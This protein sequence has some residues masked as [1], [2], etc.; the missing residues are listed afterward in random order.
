MQLTCEER[1]AIAEKSKSISEHHKDAV[2]AAAQATPST[3]KT[4]NARLK[5]WID[6]VAEGDET[7]FE[8]RLAFDGLDL[9]VAR[10]ILGT[11]G[12]TGT[13]PPPPWTDL[14]NEVLKAVAGFSRE[15][16]EGDTCAEYP[17]LKRDKPQPF[18][19]IFIPIV[20][21]ARHKLIEKAGAHYDMLARESALSLDRFLLIKLTEISCRVLELEF[22]TYMACLQFTGALYGDSARDK[23]SRKQYLNFI[24]KLCTGGLGGIFQEYCVLARRVALRIEQWIELSAEFL[25]RLHHDR[26]DI[27]KTFN[28]SAL[29]NVVGVEPGI[30]DSH[31]NGRTVI[32]LTFEKGLRLV[33]KPKDMGL[34]ACYFQFVKHLNGL[35]TPLE[36]K[37]LTVMKRDGYGWVEFA[38]HAP[39]ESLVQAQR[40]FRRSGMLLSLI[41]VFDG[42]DFHGENMVACGEHPVPIDMETFFHHRVNYPQDVKDLTSAANEIIA[43]SVLR[44][45]FLPQLYKTRDKFMDFTGMGAMPGQEVVLEVLTWKDLNTD[46]MECHLAEV[47]MSTHLRANAPQMGETYL[48]PEDYTDE[49]IDGFSS[50]YQFLIDNKNSFLAPDGLF[51]AL[52]LNK[53]R[54]VFRATSLYASILR[55]SVH[56]DYQRDGIDLSIQ[57]DIVSRSFVTLDERSGLWPMVA[58]EVQSMWNLDIPKF[59]VCGNSDSMQFSD[60]TWS[61][62]I[63]VGTPCE[64]VKGKLCRLSTQDL[65]WQVGLIRGSMEAREFRTAKMSIPEKSITDDTDS[66]PLLGVEELVLHALMLAEEMRAQSAY[67]ARGESSWVILKG[68]QNSTQFMLADMQF[69][70]YDGNPGVALFLAALEKVV[71]GS[72]YRDMSRSCVA[73]MLRWLKKARPSDIREVGIGGCSGLGSMVYT[74][75]RLSQFLGDAELLAAATF[76]GSLCTKKMIDEDKSLD[77]IGGAAGAILGLL[78]LHKATGCRDALDNARYCGAHLLRKRVLSPSGFRV[79]QCVEEAP[80]LTGFSHGAAGIGY[81]LVKLYEETNE[82]ELLF[83]AKEACAFETAIFDEKEKNWPDFRVSKTGVSQKGVPGFMSAWCHGAPGIALGRLGGVDV[84]NS[85]EIQ[86]DIQMALETTKNW[87]YQPQDHLCCGNAGRAETMLTAGMKLSKP[88]WKQEALRLTSKV[89]S[90]AK[91]GG[92]FKPTFLFDLYNPTFFQGSAGLGYHLLRLVEPEQL[93]SI[94]LLD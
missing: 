19:D 43:D 54:F 3:E 26:P 44:T 46:A 89:V 34:E 8:K 23:D 36:F 50:M 30:S 75:T 87:A 49:I 78:A 77:I 72:G 39:V 37:V 24:E 10:H 7:L 79:W 81:S 5:E 84:L 32:I 2:N 18:E 11:R 70:L 76:A 67:S 15:K 31:C 1:Y 33:Y 69:A 71:P 51:S 17:F 6:L 55:K 22:N 61:P 40:Y 74:L 83:A 4:V 63:F 73:L 28:V 92:S 65:A 13:A 62:K 52:F 90:R 91:I 29:G 85:A 59:T 9:N 21:L 64:I 25:Q 56:P 68:V 45:H 12:S 16:F 47:Q 60:G 35:G 41:Y 86:H 88:Q 58:E 93:P 48:V 66:V 82:S 80:P 38:K 94:L 20:M 53:A 27:Q 57:L 14:L 42:I